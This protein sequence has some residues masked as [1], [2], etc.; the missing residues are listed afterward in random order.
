MIP[1]HPSDNKHI[2]ES[3]WK[4]PKGR[5]FQ[6]LACF[7]IPSVFS[8]AT[9]GRVTLP[10]SRS[11]V[12]TRARQ[13]NA[14]LSLPTAPCKSNLRLAFNNHAAFPLGVLPKSPKLDRWRGGA[15]HELA[16]LF[17]SYPDAHFFSFPFLFMETGIKGCSSCKGLSR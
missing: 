3:C 4:E 8:L 1:K 14:P 5:C 15:P 17:L 6:E 11:N 7:H 10:A 13:A 9:E 12:T 16:P 2:E